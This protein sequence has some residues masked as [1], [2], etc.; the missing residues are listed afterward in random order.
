MM[1]NVKGKVGYFALQFDLAKLY[2]MLSWLY[3]NLTLQ[4]VEVPLL[5]R[6]VIMHSMMS[7]KSSIRW[8]GVR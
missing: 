5:M 7:V 2:D 4:Q 3:I 8:N 6:N 1:N